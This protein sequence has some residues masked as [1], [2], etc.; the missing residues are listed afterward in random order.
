MF[1]HSFTL[2]LYD[3]NKQNSI[4]LEVV[5]PATHA[6]SPITSKRHKT[7]NLVNT[8]KREIVNSELNV[9]Y[10]ISSMAVLSTTP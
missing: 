10:Y 9:L 1:T 5:M 3:T 4:H 8:F 7:D 6:S 2:P